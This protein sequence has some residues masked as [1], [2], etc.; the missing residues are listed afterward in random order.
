MQQ[1]EL[2]LKNVPSDAPQVRRSTRKALN[3]DASPSVSATVPDSNNIG[4]DKRQ[5]TAEH[6]A[7]KYV[8][9]G[10]IDGKPLM[11][12]KPAKARHLLRDGKAKVVGMFP[13]T[14]QLLFECENQT[15]DISLG[16]D[17]GYGNVGFSAITEK[18]ELFSGTLELDMKMSQRLSDRRM[19]RVARRGR[20]W[21]RKPRFNNRKK[22]DGWLPPSTERMYQTHITLINKLKKWLPIT[23]V[24]IELA[25]F[26]IQKINN[27]EITNIGYQ[28]GDIYGYENMRAY[29]MSR[30]NGKCQLC[31]K[32][33]KGKPSHIHHIIP[34][35]NGGTDKA[36]NLAILHSDCHKKLHMKGLYIELKRNK[37]YKDSTFMNIVRNRFWKDVHGMKA[38][39]GDI[40][41]VNRNELGLEKSH[42]NDAF[43]IADGTNQERCNHTLFGQKRKNNRGLRK[44][45][46]GRKPAIRKQRYEIQPKDMIKI[47]NK[48]M[49]TQG[50]KNFGKSIVINNKSFSVKKINKI[51]SSKTIFVNL[52][53]FNKQQLNCIA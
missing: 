29:L 36:N 28:Q 11:P 52:L 43:V 51:Y 45:Y 46:R 47:K 27:H 22:D 42:V 41:F 5:H 48:W 24:T 31:G 53:K 37:Q 38:T 14:I 19:Y 6:N 44:T 34:R 13:F 10:S 33:F 40:T 17:T 39:Y 4:V 7:T 18:N 21:Y 50:C 8:F 16:I 12:C 25:K 1:L 26:D 23:S 32:D 20:L 30:E 15:Q 3:R 9:V 35:S 49:H 2:R